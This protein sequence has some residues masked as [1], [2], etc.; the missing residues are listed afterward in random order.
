MKIVVITIGI[1]MVL[2]GVIGAYVIISFYIAK[3]LNSSNSVTF[4]AMALGIFA[5]GIMAILNG[6]KIKK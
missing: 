4:L 5:I 1:L 6:W 3:A 2:G